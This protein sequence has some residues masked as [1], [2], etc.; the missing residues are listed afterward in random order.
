MTVKDFLDVLITKA[1]VSIVNNETDDEVISV[2]N[3]TGVADNL[4]TAIQDATVKRVNVVGATSVV[5]VIES[6]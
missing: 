5:V 3:D 2:K 4:S 1:Q 6:V